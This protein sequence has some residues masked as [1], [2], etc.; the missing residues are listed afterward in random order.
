MPRRALP[1][2]ERAARLKASEKKYRASEKGREASNRLNLRRSQL[3]QSRRLQEQSSTDQA[4]RSVEP[5]VPAQPSPTVEPT[6]PEKDSPATSSD[7]SPAP[8]TPNTSAAPENDDIERAKKWEEQHIRWK[9]SNRRAQVKFRQTI[10]GQI[11]LIRQMIY[12]RVTTPR[13]NAGY[14]K[15]VEAEVRK[16]LGEEGVATLHTMK[17]N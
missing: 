8:L 12:R 6:P 14:E 13:D 2:D 16:R 10:R 3:R 7:P 17:K 11:H 9:E 5:L 15:A 1:P 4:S